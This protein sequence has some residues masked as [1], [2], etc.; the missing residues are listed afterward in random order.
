MI[1]ALENRFFRH[2]PLPVR[3]NLRFNQSDDGR[4]GAIVTS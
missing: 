3:V 4:I 1:R 2:V